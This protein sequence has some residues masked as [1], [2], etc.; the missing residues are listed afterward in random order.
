VDNEK[1]CRPPAPDGDVDLPSSWYL[2]QN[3]TRLAHSCFSTAFRVGYTN[4]H[5]VP[6]SRN[7]EIPRS[8][9]D[10]NKSSTRERLGDAVFRS[11]RRGNPRRSRLAAAHCDENRSSARSRRTCRLA[12][13]AAVVLASGAARA[14]EPDWRKVGDET[15]A[16]LADVI[17]ID[18]QNPP[19]GETPAANALARKLASEGLVAEVFESVPGRGNLYARLA[20]TGTGRPVILL[21]HL[22]VVPADA[23]AWR[24]PP[25]SGTRDHGY[26]WGRGALD[27][28]GIT[29]VELMTL[30]ALRRSGQPLPR[31]VILL[32]TA[33]EETGGRAG[34]GW[35]VQHRPE[36]LGNAEYL[37][38]EGDHIHV[39]SGGRKV[40]QVAVAEKTPCWVKL[41]AHGDAGHG[42]TPPP[43]TA[44]TRLVRALDKLRRYRTAVRVVNPVEDYF[45]A[46]SVLEREP[47]R[48]RLANLGDA[49]A[50]PVFFAEFTRNPL[51]NAL[52]RN[53]ITPT[54]LQGSAKTNV[55][56]DEASAQVDCRLLP[57]ERP[58]DFLALLRE[59]IGDDTVRVE[60]ILSFPA[61]SSDPGSG[62]MA[63][64]RAIAA[65]E[66]GNAPVVPSVIPGFTDSHYFREHG[67]ASYGFVPFVLADEDE[68]TVHGIDERISVA[69]L[70]AG[71]RRLVAL[72]R[73][74]PAL[75]PPS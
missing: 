63:A 32:A 13:L 27:A 42:S 50:D 8:D 3:P 31:D 39:L 57:G 43:E 10:V 33:D 46:L 24:F 20:G 68:R 30:V 75:S 58:A 37:L 18:T 65:S 22:D 71:V 38:T 9:R 12:A 64:V 5:G 49:L 1:A 59:V 51:Q 73:A 45:R 74:L 69:N 62:F 67:I 11:A 54:V 61:S 29:A 66:I 52:I 26:V 6:S 17:R 36:L 41:T 19:G 47:L 34:S 14:S 15:A 35:I 4:R 23:R 56:P 60:P 40:V 44:V 53:T 28:K 2:T 55:I 48:S 7:T 72:L 21:S 25:F 70:G 16:L